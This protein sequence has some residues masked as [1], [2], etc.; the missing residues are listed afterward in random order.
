[1][2]SRKR[3]LKAVA[4]AMILSVAAGCAGPAGSPGS[5]SPS[6]SSAVSSAPESSQAPAEPIT[7][8]LWGG[9]QP[10]YGY[11]AM[12]KKFN[13]EFKD[14]GI[15]M[16][17]VRY[18]NDS[19]GNLQ[20]DTY[21]MS[22]GE[23]DVFMGYGGKGR[24][25]PRKEAG[26]VMDMTDAL[27]KRGFDPVKEL[28][29]V[30]VSG[31][32]LDD[33]AY[34]LPTKY[35]NGAYW[36]AN[37]DMFKEAGVELPTEGWTDAQFLEACKKLT[38]GEGVDKVYGMYWGTQLDANLYRAFINSVLDDYV[39]YKDRDATETDFDH[40]VWKAGLQTIV[41]TMLVDKTAVTIA[42]E[43]GNSRTFANTY[44]EGKAAMA[45]GIS[46]LRLI[47]DVKTYPHD[48]KTA[49]IPAPVPSEEY[50]DLAD[51][52]HRSGAGDLIC[53]SSKTK[54]PEQAVDL[55]LWY[56]QG[57]MAPLAGGGRIPLWNGFDSQSVVDAM[58]ENAEGVFDT[59]S[60]LHYLKLDK[61]KATRP[62]ERSDVP[63][64]GT[65]INEETQ[66]AMYGKKDVDTALAD[67]K[68]RSDE[69]IAAADKAKEKK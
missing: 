33:R 42:D 18:V 16:E 21:L 6:G 23:V 53:V 8:R 26:L 32:L 11:D 49:L 30:N 50:M 67:M 14:K 58:M 44:L 45:V 31:F 38:H 62:I 59:D 52:S 29:E 37:V 3:F 65:V 25:V 57:G 46:Q 51:H 36:F 43:A 41:D 12:T 47:K 27:A 7:L 61:T 69:L 34:G 1:M 20:L 4:L 10:E 60:L 28:G 2:K 5:E 39:T 15:Q 54:Y 68:K 66:A 17:Y 40:P 19:N 56:I 24:L 48:F 9:V 64:I 35:E 63:G 22:G 55:V 13:E